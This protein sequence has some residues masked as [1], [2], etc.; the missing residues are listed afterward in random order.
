MGLPAS[1]T[2]LRNAI[3][4]PLA[5]QIVA[6]GLIAGLG[7]CAPVFRD[8]GYAPVDADLALVEVGADTR[9]TVAEKVGR[10][11]A[12]G[13]LGDRGWYYVQ[14]RWREFGAQAPREV[15]REVVA[16]TFSEAG[17]VANVERFG[18]ERG[19]VVPLSRRVTESNIQGVGILRQL[20]GN[21]G[22]V[23]AGDLIQ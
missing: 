7:A 23:R 8:S 1:A 12:T 20:L 21:L 2:R 18:L 6:F 14:S 9:E 5:R 10:P 15:E 22:N 4:R 13:L 3:A 11:S 19:R 16:I 17:T